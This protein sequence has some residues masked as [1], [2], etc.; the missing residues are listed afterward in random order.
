MPFTKQWDSKPKVCV[1]PYRIG[2]NVIC[3]NCQGGWPKEHLNPCTGLCKECIKKNRDTVHNTPTVAPLKSR[4]IRCDEY[5]DNCWNNLCS[6]CREN[7]MLCEHNGYLFPSEK[8][9]FREC[10]CLSHNQ[11]LHRLA[12]YSRRIPTS[13]TII[14]PQNNV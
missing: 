13:N 14:E 11:Q 8:I 10:F 12:L 2:E 3:H 6:L 4:C 1:Y 7:W 9:H 5:A